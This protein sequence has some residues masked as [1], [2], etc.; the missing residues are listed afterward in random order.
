MKTTGFRL[1]HLWGEEGTDQIPDQYLCQ[2][3][4][5]LFVTGADKWY[6]VVKIDRSLK[7]YVVERNEEVMALLFKA[8]SDFHTNH[9]LAEVFPPPDA[10]KK[11]SD[12]FQSITPQADKTMIPATTELVAANT[13]YES[14]KENIKVHESTKTLASNVMKEAIGNNYGILFPD[15][16]KKIWYETG[17]GTKIDWEKVA[18]DMA[19]M[20]MMDE[21]ALKSICDAHSSTTKVSRVF[22]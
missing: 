17:G 20:Y 6:V 22:R 3:H 11:W 9:L 4:W 5:N 13:A 1:A 16:T 10:T 12:V 14:A 15:G 7:H 18:S 21:H 8:V 19:K 2:V